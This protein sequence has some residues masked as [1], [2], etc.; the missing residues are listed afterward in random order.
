MERDNVKSSPRRKF[1]G[2]IAAGAAAVGLAS[3]A[4]PLPLTAMPLGE[5]AS[6]PTGPDEWFNKINGKHRMVFDVTEP[7]QGHEAMLPF[8]WPK[9]FLLTNQATGTPEKE[10]SAV[11][12]LRHNA[13]PYAMEDR[14]WA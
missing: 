14:L 3:I 8:A 5:M 12:I 4:S 7:K 2:S 1:L 9:I 11:V 6:D 10:N 13:I